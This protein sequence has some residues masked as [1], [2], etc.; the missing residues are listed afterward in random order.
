MSLD[1]HLLIAHFWINIEREREKKIYKWR[2]FGQVAWHL[3]QELNKNLWPAKKKSREALGT[4][5]YTIKKQYN[6]QQQ[7]NSN[8]LIKHLNENMQI[9]IY[10]LKWIVYSI[11]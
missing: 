8:L 6:F 5:K 2:Q 1:I 11:K 9:I 3:S 10:I 4:V 7:Q